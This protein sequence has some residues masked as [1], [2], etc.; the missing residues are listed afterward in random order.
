MKCSIC[1]YLCLISD[2]PTFTDGDAMRFLFSLFFHFF[3]F[4]CFELSDNTLQSIFYTM[5]FFTK[6]NAKFGVPVSFGVTSLLVHVWFGAC[7]SCSE[8]RAYKLLK[9]TSPTLKNTAIRT[10]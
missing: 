7:S 8:F 3:L 10:S 4:V 1:V 2:F 9:R 5:D 6:A